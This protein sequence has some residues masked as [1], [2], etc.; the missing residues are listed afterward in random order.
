LKL[1]P[2]QLNPFN[3]LLILS[4]QELSSGLAMMTKNLHEAEMVVADDYEN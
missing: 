4:R 1:S 2:N 3:Y